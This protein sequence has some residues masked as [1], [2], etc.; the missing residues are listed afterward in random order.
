M[1]TGP[2]VK[3]SVYLNVVL[4]LKKTNFFCN[5]YR[6][7]SSVHVCTNSTTWRHPMETFSALLALCVGNSTVTS[8]FPSQ[9]PVTWSF[10]V[11]FDLHLNKQLSEQSR[12]RWFEMQSRSFWRQCND[13]KWWLCCPGL[14]ELKEFSRVDQRQP[15]NCRVV[16]F[17]S[18]PTQNFQGKAWV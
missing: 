11:F 16:G 3:D 15:V 8:K 17:I 12:R 7:F 10:D 14:Y 1:D 18:D 2:S 4:S 13:T 9:R 6:K 5:Q